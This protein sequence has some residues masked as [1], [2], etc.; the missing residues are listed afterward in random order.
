MC[1]EYIIHDDCCMLLQVTA[2]REIASIA[3]II[4]TDGLDSYNSGLLDQVKNI[5]DKCLTE[6][7]EEIPKEKA[8]K[9]SRK[10][11]QKDMEY[12]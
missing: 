11:K 1:D 9:G 2:M 12:E 10:R 6:Q 5:V 4:S 3:D 7:V 8:K